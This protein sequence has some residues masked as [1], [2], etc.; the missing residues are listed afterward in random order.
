MTGP[1]DD[2]GNVNRNFDDVNYEDHKNVE[3]DYD[4]DERRHVISNQADI[5]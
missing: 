4:D 2:K 5:V 1:A 3:D